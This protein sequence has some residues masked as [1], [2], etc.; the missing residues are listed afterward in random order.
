[1]P[2]P[3]VHP[4]KRQRTAQACVLC[5]ASKKRCSGAVP[6]GHC[7]RRGRAHACEMSP[8]HS[9]AGH[10][11]PQAAA[12]A[13]ALDSTGGNPRSLS[14]EA[15]H[16]THPRMLRNLR[17]ERVYIGGAASLSFLQFIRETVVQYTGPSGFTHNPKVDSMLEN[18]SA[19]TDI[20]SHN[21]DDTTFDEKVALLRIYRLAT[22]GIIDVLSA[23]E[24]MQLLEEIANSEASVHSSRMAV[25]D[26]ILA[27]GAQCPKASTAVSQKEK[28]FF[29]RGQKRAFAGMLEDPNLELVWA[30]LLMAFYMLGACRRNAGFMYLGVA[31]RAA[32]ALGLHHE[33][34]YACLTPVDRQRRL[35]T[36]MSLCVLDLLVSSILGRPS[37]TLSLRSELGDGLVSMIEPNDR[38]QARLLAS[39]A[40]TDLMDTVTSEL[41]GQKAVSTD[42]AEEFLR[43]LD[44]WSKELPDAMRTASPNLNR[45]EEQ[46]HTLG[47]IQ[48]ACFY[49]FATMLATRPFLIS[50]L[51]ARLVR[52]QGGLSSEPPTPTAREDPTHAK[53]ASACVDSAV[54]LIQACQDARKANLFLANMCIMTALVFAASLV[55]GFAM[56]AK[57]KPDPEV[58]AAFASAKDILEIFS[59]LSAQAAH[60]FEIL[61]LLSNAVNEQ[62]QRLALQPKR[63]KSPYVGRIFSLIPPETEAF[64]TNRSADID[65]DVMPSIASFGE[66]GDPHHSWGS[67]TFLP[68]TPVQALEEGG[69]GGGEEEEEEEEA[70]FGWDSLHLP[71]WDNFP[72][73]TDPF[74]PAGD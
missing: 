36:W 49:Y 45:P 28:F 4:D 23:S 20:Q 9:G 61:V 57:N 74:I 66:A 70:F 8:L 64:S 17:G 6:C 24:A 37:A 5:R 7:V 59:L 54:Y 48:V 15:P 47:S 55:L 56:F 25:A 14:P 68:E 72:F 42:A 10:P 41:Y 21:E 13:R 3:K 27:I 60:Y 46:E 33:D 11:I 50:T 18:A 1:M 22:A 34:S 26:L 39:Y 38:A 51:T 71:V 32:V 73:L 44:R 12:G 53:L 69:G 19:A 40:I 65:P 63:N 52:S 62:R 16:K 43:K 31:T 30:F 2:R 35:K 58:E 29:T 67:P